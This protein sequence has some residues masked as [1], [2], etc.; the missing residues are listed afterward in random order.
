MRKNAARGSRTAELEIVMNDRE[1]RHPGKRISPSVDPRRHVGKCGL[2]SN[3]FP[4]KELRVARHFSTVRRTELSRTP[5]GT[6]WTG[7]VQLGLPTV[8]C[9][10]MASAALAEAWSR[11]IRIRKIRIP[12]SANIDETLTPRTPAQ[13]TKSR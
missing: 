11:S 1:A 10:L 5:L 12:L 7:S 2:V 13:L 4:E 9:S 8:C 6:L 3:G